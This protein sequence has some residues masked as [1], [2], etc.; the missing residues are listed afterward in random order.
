MG[1]HHDAKIIRPSYGEEVWVQALSSGAY[2]VGVRLNRNQYTYVELS[3][4]QLEQ[5]RDNIVQ[6]MV[7]VDA[8]L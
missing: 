4:A 8:A 2:E 6:A 7:E 1:Y 3:R 5:Y